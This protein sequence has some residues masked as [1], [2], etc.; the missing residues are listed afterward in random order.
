MMI[1]SLSQVA[2]ILRSRDVITVLTHGHPDGD[3][4]GSATALCLALRSMGKKA[5]LSIFE[6]IPKQYRFMTDLVPKEETEPGFVMS[7]DVAD[8]KLLDDGNKERYASCVQLAVDHHGTNRLFAKQTYLEAESASCCEIIY[9]LIRELGVE[10]TKDMASCLFTGCST[11]TGC[12]KYSNV[13][14]RTHRIAADLIELGA[15]AAK[16][17]E[18]MFDTKTFAQLKLQKMCL[19]SYELLYDGR[20]SLFII[21]DEMSEESGCSDADFDFIVALARQIE[22]VKVG[23]TLKQKKDGSFKASVRTNSEYD[24][25]AFCSAFGGGGHAKAAGCSFYCSAEEARAQ[26]INK[27]KE[28]FEKI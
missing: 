15:E 18:A 4:I 17:N 6:E 24:A 10:I 22:G 23:I 8:V 28:L 20:M 25:A 21:T 5:N 2:E 13:T 3:T 14:P 9:L 27:A 16:I 1:D 11:D 12:F 19:D 26:L 7:V